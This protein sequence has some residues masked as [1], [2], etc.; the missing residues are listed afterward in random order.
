MHMELDRLNREVEIKFTRKDALDM[1]KVPKSSGEVYLFSACLWFHQDN[2]PPNQNPADPEKGVE[3]LQ[4]RYE[5][6]ARVCVFSKNSTE[7][8]PPPIFPNGFFVCFEHYG[9]GKAAAWIN[10]RRLG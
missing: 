2:S 7:K 10:C 8:Y 1:R 5:C 3:C 6:S 9:A 4:T